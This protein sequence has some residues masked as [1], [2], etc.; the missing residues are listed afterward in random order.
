M[1]VI[2]APALSGASKLKLKGAL[3]TRGDPAGLP[4]THCEVV[5]T[6]AAQLLA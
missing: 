3:P 6:L 2:M 4:W 5:G 1:G